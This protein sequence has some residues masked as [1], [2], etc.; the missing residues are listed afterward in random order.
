VT[1]S[2][3]DWEG[4]GAIYRRL[5]ELY[6]DSP[7]AQ[8][9]RVGL[10]EL[11]LSQGAD[12]GAAVRLFEQYLERSAQGPLAEE[13]S[14]GVC[15]ALRASGRFDEERRALE[16]FLASHPSSPRAAAVR[17]RLQSSAGVAVE[18]SARPT[19]GDAPDL[20]KP[21]PDAGAGPGGAE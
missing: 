5:L 6:P 20:Q 21:A 9:A 15:R 3:R 13:A 7:E 4:A 17:D 19:G 2:A 11:L 14:Y 10:G 8:T 18:S 16:R 12:P 1:R